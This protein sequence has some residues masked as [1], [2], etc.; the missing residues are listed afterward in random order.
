MSWQAWATGGE[1]GVLDKGTNSC[2]DSWHRYN[3]VSFDL[4]TGA[5]LCNRSMAVVKV[6]AF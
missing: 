4:K 6:H 5:S 1:N 3:T 2:P